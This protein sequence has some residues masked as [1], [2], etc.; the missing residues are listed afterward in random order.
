M[1]MRGVPESKERRLTRVAQAS[2]LRTDTAI[3][4]PQDAL[5]HLRLSR[6]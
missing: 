4:R 1:K 2:S 5:D 6:P 3:R